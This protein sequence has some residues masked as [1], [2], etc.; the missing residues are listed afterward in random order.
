MRSVTAGSSG[1]R[2]LP[3]AIRNVLVDVWRDMILLS[4]APACEIVIVLP[5]KPIV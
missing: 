5:W 1:L 4:M 3:T 2:L